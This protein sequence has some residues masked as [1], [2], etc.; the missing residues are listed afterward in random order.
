[1]R[2]SIWSNRFGADR[3][4]FPTVMGASNRATIIHYY[5][6]DRIIHPNDLC[7]MD[8]GCEMNGYVSDITRVWAGGSKTAT[9]VND[10]QKAV[11]DRVSRCSFRGSREIRARY[12]L[13]N[14]G[15]VI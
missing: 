13:A 14:V 7:L 2:M 4:A 10:Y 1:M 12:S 11:Y 15:I 6:N 3:L 5:Q 9:F 8:A